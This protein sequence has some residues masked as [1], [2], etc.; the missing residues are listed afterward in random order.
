MANAHDTVVLVWEEERSL[1]SAFTY[2]AP[3][4]ADVQEKGGG[5]VLRL[6]CIPHP[7]A[8][9]TIVPYLPELHSATLVGTTHAPTTLAASANLSTLRLGRGVCW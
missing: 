9:G 6:A 7:V 1:A 3:A 8:S 5:L 2:A 4:S